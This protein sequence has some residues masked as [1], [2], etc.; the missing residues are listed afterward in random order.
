VNRTTRVGV[1]GLPRSG[2]SWLGRTLSLAEGLTY[3]REPDNFDHVPGASPRFRFLYLPAGSDDAEYRR[4][5]ERALSGAIA[6]HFT[7]NQDPGPLLRRLPKRWW[8]I[9]DHAPVLFLRGSEGLVKLVHSN[10]ALDFLLERFPEMRQVYIVRHP[11]GQFASW[12]RQGWTPTPER[13]VQ[14]TRLMEDHLAPFADHIRR[15]DGFWAKAGVWWGA[16]NHVVHRQTLQ[17]PTRI[18]VA[19]EWLCAAP[20]DHYRQLYDR[21]GLVWTDATDRFLRES[22]RRGKSGKGADRPY[23]L[24]RD[25]SQQATRWKQEV[26]AAEIAECRAAAE[27]FDLPY[28]PDFE[29]EPWGPSWS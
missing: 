16:V 14:D 5:M 1:A 2:T 24:V 25:T 23:S 9:G 11:C 10:L 18:I 20:E 3:Y 7:M 29:P 6:T 22:N 15:A 19:F 13:L 27:P 8:S 21:L 28:Y 17:R 26:D 4:H 12:R